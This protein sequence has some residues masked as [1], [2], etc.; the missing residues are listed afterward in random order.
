MF[1]LHLLIKDRSAFGVELEI[2]RLF[3]NSRRVVPRLVRLPSIRSITY[4]LQS[5]KDSKNTIWCTE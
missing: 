1:I 5:R 2:K 3:L 4:N